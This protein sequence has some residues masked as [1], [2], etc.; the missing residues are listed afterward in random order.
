[1]HELAVPPDLHGL[2]WCRI[3]A[4]RRQCRRL[5]RRWRRR[6]RRDLNADA[7]HGLDL[8]PGVAQGKL[9]VEAAPLEHIARQSCPAQQVVPLEAVLVE[10][11]ELE[12]VA[13]RVAGREAPRVPHGVLRTARDAGAEARAGLAGE[14]AHTVGVG[15]GPGQP[16]G[17]PQ[18]PGAHDDDRGALALRGLRQRGARAVRSG[19]CVRSCHD[20]HA[21][22]APNVRWRFPKV[23]HDDRS[24]KTC[25]HK[26]Q[27]T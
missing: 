27:R 21:P 7:Q 23:A 22:L 13:G 16:I 17:S 14:P 2:G 10:E 24:C 26:V 25:E 15:G 12:V 4:M 1:M 6:G 18:V 9:P 3:P 5:G 11:L 20:R 19:T 8:V